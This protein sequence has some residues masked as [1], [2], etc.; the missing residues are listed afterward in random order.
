M[1]IDADVLR[2]AFQLD[3]DG[4]SELL[5]SSTSPFSGDTY[6]D[7]DGLICF[8]D[9]AVHGKEC[10]IINVNEWGLTLA[11]G[12]SG[13][14]CF[15]KFKGGDAVQWNVIDTIQDYRDKT[16]EESEQWM[17]YEAWQDYWMYV[18]NNTISQDHFI[19]KIDS[20]LTLL[21][22]HHKRYIS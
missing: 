21:R 8:N 14:V 20:I 16:L 7:M 15:N 5:K 11:H 13:E 18:S 3:V 1:M 17:E 6:P 9:C 19:T 12:W 2:K 22:N 4:I 10:N